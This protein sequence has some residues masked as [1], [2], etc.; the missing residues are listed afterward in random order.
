MT[1]FENSPKYEDL[2]KV[3]PIFPLN[4]VLILPGSE[5]PLH[6]FEKRYIEMLK[7]SIK[8]S[9]M[10]GIVQPLESNN[11][12]MKP[13]LYKVGCA[14]RIIGYRE[15]ED[16]RYFIT[17]HGICRFK[18]SKENISNTPYRQY[19]VDYSKY[20]NDFSEIDLKQN[21]F[22]RKILFPNLKL[23]LSRHDIKIDFAALDSVA[24]SIII[25]SLAM[26]CPFEPNE[27][28]FI[29]EAT[30]IEE[31]AKIVSSLIEISIKSQSHSNENNQIQ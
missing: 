10:I 8:T 18:L 7:D 16:G 24:D 31:R 12:D 1:I 29:L 22:D 26:T 21:L 14:G 9:S 13:D 3:I 15:T 28:Q 4:G 20:K 17:L 5:L 25:Q 6:I 30:S 11:L 23:Y 19:T 27:K 2:P